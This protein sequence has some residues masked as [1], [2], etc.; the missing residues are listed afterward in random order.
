[1]LVVRALL[2]LVFVATVCFFYV[3]SM[4]DDNDWSGR[5]ASRPHPQQFPQRTGTAVR[6]AV[7]SYKFVQLQK[8]YIQLYNILHRA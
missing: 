1:M 5:V 6:T 2:K 3:S 4:N 8:G 7:Y